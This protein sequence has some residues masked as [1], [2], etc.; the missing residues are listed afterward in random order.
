MNTKNKEAH[1]EIEELL[2]WHAAGTLS[3][4]DARR[5]EEALAQDPELARRYA[6]VRDELGETI[7]LNE[8]LGAPSARAMEKLFA[9]IDAEPARKPAV[10][11]NIG[12][13]VAEFL[14]S[15]SPRTL[16]YAGGAAV[17]AILLQAGFI[18]GVMLKETSTSGFET[19]SAPSTDPGVGAFT[20]I[21]F[22]PQATQD[23]VTKFLAAN[24]LSIASGPMA[25]G[26]YKVRVAVT[27]LPKDELATIVKKLQAD[28]VVTFIATTE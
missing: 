15:F 3:R 22:A 11:L 14:A 16:A 23:D 1:S 21:R 24:K 7:H 9:K 8:T 26:L 20:L 25:G 27:G 10:S 18:A 13:R 17:L 28:K 5:V 12:A 6:L 2:P 19:A 4:N